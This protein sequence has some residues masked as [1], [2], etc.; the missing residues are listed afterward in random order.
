MKTRRSLVLGATLLGSATAFATAVAPLQVSLSLPQAV[1]QGEGAVW[2]EVQVH[3]PGPRAVK[4]LRW[5][6][7][8]GELQGPLFEVLDAQ[9]RAADYTGPLVKRPAPRAEDFVR[10]APGQT[11]SYRVDLG[12]RYA[13]GDGQYQV[14]YRGLS[15]DARV[16]ELRSGAAVPLWTSGRAA[17]PQALAP[18]GIDPAVGPI[19]Y[20]GACT[21]SEKTDL[22]TAAAEASTYATKAKRY[23]KAMTGG[24]ARYTTW[25][26]AHDASRWGTVK[27]H[28]GKIDSAFKQQTLTLDCSCSDNGVYAYVYP[29]APYK[30]YLCGA[31]WAAPMKG[32]DSK[33][34]TLIHEMSHFTVVAGT[35]DH[36]Y[37]QAAA[38]ALALSDPA[39]AIANADSHEY[40]AENTPAQP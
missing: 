13:L 34:G 32:T 14:R 39:K 3:N 5:Q 37:G 21:A 2:V 38:K 20:T 12:A 17:L 15:A 19:V 8:E 26:G 9:G 33:A 1:V 11:L 30:I 16:G 10:I 29:N 23:L 6:L 35:K 36:A 24:T 31:F 18:Q 4:V 40:F 27:T 7:P 25:F 28:F 22:A